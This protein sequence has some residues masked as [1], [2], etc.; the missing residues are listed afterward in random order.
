MRVVGLDRMHVVARL[1]ARERQC[2]RGI[3]GGQACCHSARH[4]LYH[5]DNLR[6]HRE[7]HQ[8]EMRQNHSIN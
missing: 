7:R 8:E 4:Q 5:S 1:C 3:R 6:H 2:T